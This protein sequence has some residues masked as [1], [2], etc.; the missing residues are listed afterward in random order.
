MS[1]FSKTIST[2]AAMMASPVLIV[3]SVQA[4]YALDKSLTGKRSKCFL[5]LNLISQK[6][7]LKDKQG[8]DMNRAP[9]VNAPQSLRE[10]GREQQC[11]LK[12]NSNL[13]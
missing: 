2:L 7:L 1:A 6:R 4:M 9:I 11:V 13:F 10:D 12:D 5:L 8:M 3:L